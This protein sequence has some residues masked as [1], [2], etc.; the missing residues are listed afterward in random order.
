MLRIV[1]LLT[2]VLLSA[3]AA[4]WVQLTDLPAPSP[5][6]M[7]ED[8]GCMAYDAGVDLIYA[9]K[10]NKTGEFFECNVYDDNAP[11]TALEPI[12][13]G[14]ELEPVYTGSVICSDANGN[15][16]VTKGNKTVGFW[17]YEVMTNKWRPLTA[18]P[19]GPSGEKVKEGAGLAFAYS[20]GVGSVYLLKGHLNEFYKYDPRYDKWTPMDDAPTGAN[21][22]WGAGSWLVSDPTYGT[23]TLYAFKAKYHE[24][25][26]YDTDLEEWN[27]T[28]KAQLP[29]NCPHGN[30]IKAKEGS[31]A[32]WYDGMIYAFKGNKTTEFWRY[33]PGGD[34]W[35]EQDRIPW[36]D[37]QT[38][39]G[40]GGALAGH[41]G[42]GVYGFK[43]NGTLE[44][45]RFT[46]DDK[47][48]GAQP[49]REGIT[50]SSSE[51]GSVSFAIAPNPLSGG[52]ATVRYGL[53]KAGAAELSVYNVAG[54]TVM[55]Q[56]LPARQSG[57]A[58][59][60]LRRLNNGVYLVKLQSQD[61]AVIQKLVVQR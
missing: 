23:H 20:H 46:P 25:Y 14:A 45:W 53:P 42:T 58:D 40:A 55:A 51:I 24:L 4:G 17:G 57:S 30:N 36:G 31:C 12:P 13:L 29:F 33:D 32:A 16:Y 18:V 11:W 34:E 19:L 15:L 28:A 61:F 44:F 60:D 9:S 22:H 26:T 1:G 52:L 21:K 7:I 43:G 38:N 47:A 56:T 54:Q 37:D 10:G 48:G 6:K 5:E 2:A 50:A 3:A 27:Y 8:G 35:Q 39:V 41:P 59:L 49:S